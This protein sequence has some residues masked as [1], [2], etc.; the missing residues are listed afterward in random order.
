MVNFAQIAKPT[1]L[2][3]LTTFS[4]PFQKKVYLSTIS[5]SWSSSLRWVQCLPCIEQALLLLYLFV[6]QGLEVSWHSTFP[7]LFYFFCLCIFLLSSTCSEQPSTTDCWPGWW[8]KKSFQDSFNISV[9]RVLLKR[10]QL[11]QWWF[12]WNMPFSLNDVAL[13]KWLRAAYVPS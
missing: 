7:H 6:V 4:L 2:S 11:G 1:P 10:N 5:V 13:L 12:H 3:H 9:W 8:L